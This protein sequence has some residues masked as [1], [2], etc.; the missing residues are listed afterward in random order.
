MDLG[1]RGR[2]RMEE[3]RSLAGRP[4]REGGRLWRTEGERGGSEGGR[5]VVGFAF[6]VVCVWLLK[7]RF[8]HR[9]CS[10][11][12]QCKTPYASPILRSIVGVSLRA[13][14]I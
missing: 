10:Y 4:G 8:L 14:L 11:C 13:L 12:A 1:E 3:R 5:G 9:V 2:Q 7:I 6:H